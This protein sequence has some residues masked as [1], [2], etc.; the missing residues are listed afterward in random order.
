MVEGYATERKTLERSRGCSTSA[1]NEL[2]KREKGGKFP[3]EGGNRK[4]GGGK[5]NSLFFFL[6]QARVAAHVREEE[7]EEEEEEYC[8]DQFTVVLVRCLFS[9]F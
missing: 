9:L 4:G 7:K 3:E 8:R 5:W 6:F 2:I 1:G